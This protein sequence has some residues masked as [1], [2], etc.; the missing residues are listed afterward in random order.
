MRDLKD[1]RGVRFPDELLIKMFFKEQL[2]LNPGSV[3][4]YGCA[5]ANNLMLFRSFGWRVTGVDLS[6]T[7]VANARHNLEDEGTIIQC[8]LSEGVPDLGA[9]TFETVLVPNMNYYLPRAAF[10]RLLGECRRRIKPNGVFF[11]RSRLPDDWRWGRGEEL[12][13]NTFRLNCRETGEFGVLNVFYD[14]GELTELIDEHFGRL[15][16]RQLLRVAFENPQ[17]GIVIRNSDVVIWGRA[18]AA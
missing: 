15:G 17:G 8:D 11:L 6:S 18:A 16:S 10:I 12:G 2:H 4:E 9:A 7:S 13:P 5:S 3:L 14:V 1:L